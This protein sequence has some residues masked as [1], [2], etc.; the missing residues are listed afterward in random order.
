MASQKDNAHSFISRE[1]V[2]IYLKYANRSEICQQIVA[3]LWFSPGK[4]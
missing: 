4:N 2:L 3:N 1:Q